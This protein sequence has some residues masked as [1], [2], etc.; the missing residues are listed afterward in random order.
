MAKLLLYI[1]AF[2]FVVQPI[3]AQTTPDFLR[4][5]SRS[6]KTL[7]SI[8][9]GTYVWLTLSNKMGLEGEIKEIKQDSVFLKQYRLEVFYTQWYTKEYDTVARYTVAVHY[10]DIRKIEYTQH[11]P[12]KRLLRLTSSIMQI[13]GA[14]YAGLNII[15]GLTKNVP[16]FRGENLGRLGIAAGV[17]A[18]GR[19]LSRQID[20][21]NVRKQRI[22][23]VNMQ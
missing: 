20:P 8:Y 2:L 21:T 4:I 15:N 14:G 22:E 9:P 1:L 13:G 11:K 23:Y 18:A 19:I 6:G 10:K 16:V 5:K 3:K 12:G 17:F 7:K